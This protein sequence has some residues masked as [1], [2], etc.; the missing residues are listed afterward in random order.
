[1]AVPCRAIVVIKDKAKNDDRQWWQ[2]LCG[3]VIVVQNKFRTVT[4][5]TSGGHCH[6]QSR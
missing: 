2:C 5:S 1:M 4:M 6:A 3:T